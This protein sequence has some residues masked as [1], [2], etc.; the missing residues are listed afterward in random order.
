MTE[1]PRLRDLIALTLRSPR[2]A[3]GH[4]IALNLSRG[5]LWQALLLVVILSVLAA[6]VSVLVSFGTLSPMLDTGEG[7]ISPLFASPLVLGL[8]QGVLLLISILATYWIGRAMGGTGSF[9]AVQ[10]TVCWLQFM[11]LCLQLVQILL[12]LLIP[13]LG[14]MIGMAG[15]VVFFWLFTQFVTVVHGFRNPG[16][17]FLAILISLT[18][19]VLGVSILMASLGITFMG[20]IPD[21]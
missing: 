15:I 10:V 8:M 2:Q 21:V 9:E 20:E 3:A 16:L 5:I 14:A 7:M 19:F 1:L 6:Q 12:S 18:G 17:V 11:M 13:P 4:L